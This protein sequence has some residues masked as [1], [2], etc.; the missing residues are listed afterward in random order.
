[1]VG[2]DGEMF[3]TFIMDGVWSCTILYVVSFKE[4]GRIQN[5]KSVDMRFSLP[6]KRSNHYHNIIRE[7]DIDTK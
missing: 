4:E 1:M 2:L 7:D 5:D 6:P 3:S